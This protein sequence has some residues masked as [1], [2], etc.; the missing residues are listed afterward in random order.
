MKTLSP[1]R[2]LNC[3]QL[4][5]LPKRRVMVTSFELVV[6]SPVHT[7]IEEFTAASS[8]KNEVRVSPCLLSCPNHIPKS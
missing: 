1:L 8:Y 6:A 7:T 3:F 4:P 2:K 5:F